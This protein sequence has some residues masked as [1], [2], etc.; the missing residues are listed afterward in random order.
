MHLSFS[1]LSE[2]EM[3][4]H[5]SQNSDNPVTPERTLYFIEQAKNKNKK[6]NE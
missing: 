1:E 6:E 2:I 3:E 5:N 4:F